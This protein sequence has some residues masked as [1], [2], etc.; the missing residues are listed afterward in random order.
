[1]LRMFTTKGDKMKIYTEANHPKGVGLKDFEPSK[2]RQSELEMC[3]IN[4][5]VSRYKHTGVLPA[6]RNAGIYADVS[7]MGD[8]RTALEQVRS[9]DTLFMQLP[10]A[11]R[12]KFDNDAAK[13]LDFVSDPENMD[14]MI[15]MGLVKKA[16]PEVPPVPIEEPPGDP[17]VTP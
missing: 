2:T 13:F 15:E 3:D 14:D 11:T 4:K 8:Y 12:T 5:I 1:M 7:E 6:N 16:A 17:P 10:A 9:A